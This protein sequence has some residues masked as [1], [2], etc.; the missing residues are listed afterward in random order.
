MK[1]KWEKNW[2]IH[3]ETLWEL[4]RKKRNEEREEK[5]KTNSEAEF[6]I[7][8]DQTQWIKQNS[9]SVSEEK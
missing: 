4:L 8:L 7:T 2:K 5:I 3:G 1:F 9:G 6:A